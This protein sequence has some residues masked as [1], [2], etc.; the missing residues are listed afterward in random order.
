MGTTTPAR[1]ST[2]AG[3]KREDSNMATHDLHSAADLLRQA[4]NVN[5]RSQH[6][7]DEDV[8]HIGSNASTPPG[9]H[10]PR[11]DL[12]DKRLPG[13]IHSYLDRILLLRLR[14]HDRKKAKI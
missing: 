4:I 11:P 2:L 14:A 1:R 6:H 12:V 9:A 5:Q 7:H 3:R 10:T 8:D 13:I